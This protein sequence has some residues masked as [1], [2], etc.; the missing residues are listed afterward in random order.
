[1]SDDPDDD[2]PDAPGAQSRAAR[3]LTMRTSGATYDQIAAEVG[4]TNRGSAYRAVKTELGRRKLDDPPDVHDLDDRRLDSMLL[5]LWRKAMNGDGWAVDR[6]LRIMELRAR[7]DPA[8][9]PDGPVQ[10]S[11]ESDLARLPAEQ[12]DG[13]LA[14]TA[15]AL[16]RNVD[17]GNT[18][19]ACARELRAVLAE[20]LAPL[21]PAV[22]P[23]VRGKGAAVAD[24][25]S[26][27]A[28]RRRSTPG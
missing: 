22:E 7:P 2:T 24:L 13:A 28:A 16:A 17:Q 15:R 9:A 4:Y 6:I 21:A 3:A 5:A 10:R 12:R 11:V 20:L 18:P 26:R 27:I 25:S 1:M 8:D 19:S 23:P 14:A